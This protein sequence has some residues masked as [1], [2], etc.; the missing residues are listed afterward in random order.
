MP[1]HSGTYAF[2]WMFTPILAYLKDPLM[3]TKLE[4]KEKFEFSLTKRFNHSLSHYI[5]KKSLSLNKYK[6]TNSYQLMIHFSIIPK[7]KVKT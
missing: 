3:E 6:W 7:A 1:M 4:S 2:N 5:I